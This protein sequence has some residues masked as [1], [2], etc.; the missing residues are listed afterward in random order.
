MSNTNL[1]F[2][3]ITEQLNK[4]KKELDAFNTTKVKCGIIG[5]SGTGKSSLINAIVGE[6]VAKVGEVETTM[7]IGKPYEH[8]GLLFFDLP[9]CGTNNFPKETYINDLDIKELDCVVLVTAERFYEDD[10]FLINE[11]FKLDIAVF[12]VRT[13]VDF[14]IERGERRGVSKSE[15]LLSL[16]NDLSKNL[17]GTKIKGLYLTSADY[18]LE[19]DLDKL[20]NDIANNLSKIK[21]ERFIA[22]VNATSKKMIEEKRIV[23]D[24]IVSRY[25]ALSAANGLNPIPGLDVSVDIGLLLKMGNDISGIYGLNKEQQEFYKTFLDLPDSSKI[26]AV[27]GKASQYA[28]KY[29]GKEA[30]MIIL[31]KFVAATASKSVSKWIPFVG[32]AIA[33]GIGFKMTSS[34]GNDMVNEAEEIAIELFD[35]LKK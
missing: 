33:A 7:E 26:K 6:E 16:Y 4:F 21:K 28:A 27:L 14:S 23:A 17:E 11:L 12:T 8:K 34:L 13:K 20:L 18:P 24:N 30:I 31:K 3:S 10:L 5:R 1:D 22:D 2:G 32:Q 9:G 19:F 25:A 15:T 29:L 35:S